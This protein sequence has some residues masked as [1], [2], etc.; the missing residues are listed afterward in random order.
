MEGQST[1]LRIYAYIRTYKYYVC[2]VY[3]GLMCMY[4]CYQLGTYLYILCRA[5]EVAKWSGECAGGTGRD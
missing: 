3:I 2:C 5:I 4:V 1:V